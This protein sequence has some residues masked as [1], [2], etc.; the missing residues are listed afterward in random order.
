MLVYLFKRI[1]HAL[2]VA[3]GV[4]V[5]CFL[6]VHI[7]PGDPLTSVLPP[8]ASA[9]LQEEMRR[10]YGFDRP[11]PVQYGL[12]AIK[13]LQGDLGTSIATGRPVATELGKAIGN[14]LMLAVLAT[15][16]GFILGS[17][18]GGLFVLFVPNIA[19]AISK[20]A[21]GV[22]YG[23]ILILFL[24]LLPDGFAGLLR[25]IAARLTRSTR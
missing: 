1:T 16:I 2:P 21:P 10:I 20:A 18:F 7:A 11:L 6:L 23:V 24:F 3:F 15:L 9:Q 13:T 22:I 17:L 12:W 4:S 5:V 25:R 19:E 14:T 8:D